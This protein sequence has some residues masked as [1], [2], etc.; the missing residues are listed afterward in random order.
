MINRSLRRFRKYR[1]L[2]ESK[3]RI[4]EL[5]D[6]QPDNGNQ[7]SVFFWTTHKCASV[8]APEILLEIERCS[9]R[10]YFNY[11]SAIAV[12]GPSLKYS[13]PFSLEYISPVDLYRTVE[14]VYGPLRTPFTFTGIERCKHIFFL[15]DPRDV[16]VSAYYSFGW[17]HSIPM[18]EQEKDRFIKRREKIRGGNIDDYCLEAAQYWLQPIFERYREMS[19]NYPNQIFLSY[20]AFVNDTRQFLQH[21]FE[22]TCDNWDAKRLEVLADIAQPLSTGD[23]LRDHKRSGALNQYKEALGPATIEELNSIF[24]EDLSFWG[25]N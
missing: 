9:N 21:I 23:K 19:A 7:R 11:A 18:H 16:L 14:E 22:F 20:N 6:V 24:K 10:S 4:R 3:K 5:A 13:S 25:F 8:F 17:S 15:R 1:A 12:L 2:Q